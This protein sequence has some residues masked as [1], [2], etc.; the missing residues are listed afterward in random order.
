MPKQDK[1]LGYNHVEKSLEVQF[2]ID[3][4]IEFSLQEMPSNNNPEKSYTEKKKLSLSL[5]AGRHLQNVY[6]M[7]QKHLII[8]EEEIILKSCVKA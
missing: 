7:Q 3:V 6:L 2:E 4:D 5:Q 1:I 8:T